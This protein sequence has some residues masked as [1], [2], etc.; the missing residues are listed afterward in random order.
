VAL[1][2]WLAEHEILQVGPTPADGASWNPRVGVILWSIV[3]LIAVALAGR[4]Y[5]SRWAAFIWSVIAGLAANGCAVAA[6]WLHAGGDG[7]VAH[8]VWF[9]DRGYWTIVTLNSIV[10]AMLF[11]VIVTATWGIRRRGYA[12]MNGRG[13]R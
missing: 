6:D 2:R 9:G 7:L 10:T 5:E 3:L 13:H 1:V 4:L 11:A 8:D 12:A